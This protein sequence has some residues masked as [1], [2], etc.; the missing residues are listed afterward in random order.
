MPGA[1]DQQA[2]RAR[3]EIPVEVQ[4]VRIAGAPE[5]GRDR[6]EPARPVDAE[7]LVD[8]RIVGQERKIRPLGQ[9]ANPGPRM[10]GTERA[11]QRR[12]QEDISDRTEPHHENVDRQEDRV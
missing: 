6:G 9:H 5:L 3:P 2:E 11:E 10:P 7:D 12:G 1:R 4:Q 8:V